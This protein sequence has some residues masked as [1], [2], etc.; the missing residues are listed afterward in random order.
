MLNLKGKTEAR[1]PRRASSFAD[2]V[3]AGAALNAPLRGGLQHLRHA[4]Q[5]HWTYKV[6][7]LPSDLLRDLDCY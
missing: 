2:V 3:G 4:V 6:T 7:C 1:R 5:N